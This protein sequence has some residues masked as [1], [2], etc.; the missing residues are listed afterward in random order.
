MNPLTRLLN[1][2]AA[3]KYWWIVLVSPINA[4]VSLKALFGQWLA[5]NTCEGA[6]YFEPTEVP[7]RVTDYSELFAIPV[8]LTFQVFGKLKNDD[9]DDWGFQ[10][11][12]RCS[13]KQIK[14]SQFM[15]KHWISNL[16]EHAYKLKCYSLAGNSDLDI[17]SLNGNNFV[18]PLK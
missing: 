6:I 10:A 5:H 3:G 15:W 1:S 12:R 11:L 4:A 8:I 16:K 18:F 17:F 9:N 13:D 14:H 2:P 7:L